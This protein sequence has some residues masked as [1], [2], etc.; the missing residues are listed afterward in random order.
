MYNCGDMDKNKNKIKNL[1]RNLK[2][3]KEYYIKRKK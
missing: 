3:F 2:V 1:R